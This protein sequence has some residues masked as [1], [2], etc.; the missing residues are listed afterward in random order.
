MRHTP[1][2]KKIVSEEFRGRTI[3][4]ENLKQLNSPFKMLSS[5]AVAGFEKIGAD[6]VFIEPRIGAY[7]RKTIQQS[8]SSLFGSSVF[9]KRK[10]EDV[11]EGEYFSSHKMRINLRNPHFF[12]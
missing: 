7:F 2:I 4:I 9:S 5:L 1:E 6:S 10:S 3:A 12:K 8:I 11:S